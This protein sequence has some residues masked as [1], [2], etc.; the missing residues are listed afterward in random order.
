MKNFSIALF[1]VVFAIFAT[2]CG[3]TTYITSNGDL[4]RTW[5]CTSAQLPGGFIYLELDR[6]QYNTPSSFMEE[7]C[8][9]PNPSNPNDPNCFQ[10]EVPAAN[11][12]PH[13]TMV[14]DP[15]GGST[16]T[17]KYILTMDSL[18]IEIPIDVT[19]GSP[20]Q[21]ILNCK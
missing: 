2:S 6:L 3:D 17:A 11:F 7:I 20:G 19:T 5:R 21:S 14:V 16:M 18:T 13:G 10:I 9:T 1:L 15:P 12:S 4:F 8:Q